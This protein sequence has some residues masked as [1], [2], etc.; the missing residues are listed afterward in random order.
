MR[1]E[2]LGGLVDVVNPEGIDLGSDEARQERRARMDRVLA[3]EDHRRRAEE[4]KP[5]PDPMVVLADLKRVQV[6]VDYYFNNGSADMAD[7]AGVQLAENRS[8]PIYNIMQNLNS[9]RGG[10][11]PGEEINLTWFAHDLNKLNLLPEDP[12]VTFDPSEMEQDLDRW[13]DE[14]TGMVTL[15]MNSRLSVY[16][17]E[18]KYQ[19]GFNCEGFPI[20]IKD[21]VG[22]DMIFEEPEGPEELVE[23]GEQ[24]EAMGQVEEGEDELTLEQKK[25]KLSAFQRQIMLSLG[26]I[27]RARGYSIFAS[28]CETE[29]RAI[30]HAF[31]R[32]KT[33]RLDINIFDPFNIEDDGEGGFRLSDKEPLIGRVKNL[34]ITA[35]ELRS[36]SS[37]LRLTITDGKLTKNIP[38]DTIHGMEVSEGE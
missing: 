10:F 23:D 22:I 36:T 13:R 19:L 29:A 5:K 20:L 38:Y 12:H 18:C 37:D 32:I 15:A 4:E 17:V 14:K 34:K 31:E 33:I 6:I 2:G 16:I 11:R 28:V 24:D 3:D 27:D 8:W 7:E 26:E 9:F 35:A 21:C 30:Q 1:Q 25:H